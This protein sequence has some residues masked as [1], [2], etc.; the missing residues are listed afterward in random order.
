LPD[1][2]VTQRGGLF[3]LRG[4]GEDVRDVALD[5][6]AQLAALGCQHDRIGEATLIIIPTPEN[7]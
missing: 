6:G 4:Q 7:G 2:P 1:K 3:A 5:V